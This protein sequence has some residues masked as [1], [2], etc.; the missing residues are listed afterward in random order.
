MD[1]LKTLRSSI[2]EVKKQDKPE[3]IAKRC[4]EILKEVVE[5]AYSESNVKVPLNASLLELI[6][7]DVM[8]AY[9]GDQDIRNALHYVRIL[10]MNAEHGKRVKKREANLAINNIQF[11]IDFIS[12]KNSC[13]GS[14]S[15]SK[16]KYMS[17][18][19]TRKIYIDKYLEEAGWE[20]VEAKGVKIPGKASVEI[21]VAGMP[22]GQKK[23]YC[24]YV[25]YGRDGKPLAIVEAKKS[26]VDPIKGR[27]QVDLYGDCMKAVY[28]YKPILYYTNGYSIKIMDGIYP[29]RE[30]S[31]FHTINELELMLQRRNRGNIVDLTIND[32]ITNRPYQKMAITNL[33]EHFNSMRRR[34][35]LVM[36]TGTGKT[37]VAVSLVDVL[38]RNKWVKNVL[39]LADRTALVSQAKRAFNSLLPDMSICELSGSEEKD[40]NARLMF[41]TYQTMIKYIDSENKEFSIGRFDLIIIDEA[42]R[43]V[44]NKYGA[45]FNYFD[46][47]LIGLTATPKDEVDSNTYTLFGCESGVPN[48]DYTLKD[49][50]GEE[51]LVPYKVLNKTT[52]LYKQGTKYNDLS[53][54]EKDDLDEYV[55]EIGQAPEVVATKNE[56][57]KVLY[58]KDTCRK[59]LEDA[60]NYGIKVNSGETIAKTII[61][62]YD[63][64]HA[65]LIVD[66]FHEMYPALDKNYCQLVDNYVNYAD[67]LVLKFDTDDDFR[68]A[69]SVDMLDT[70]ID[71][72]AVSNLIFFKP[73]KSK[74]K[75]LQM[76]GRGTRLCPNLFGPG[77][78]KKYFLIF[79]YCGNFEYFEE[80]PEGIDPKQTYSLSQATFDV[81]LD[82]LYELQK[83]QYQQNPYTKAYYDDLKKTLRQQ[84]KTVKTH[85]ERVM[86]RTEMQYIDKYCQDGLWDS[87]SAV[88]VREMQNHITKVIDGGSS[89][90]YQARSFDY[91]MLKVQKAI[92][93]SGDL[94]D[95][96]T[97]IRVIRKQAKYL[98]DKKASVPQVLSK[99]NDLITLGNE[100]FWKA[101]TFEDI[102]DMRLAVRDVMQFVDN[103]H[104][105]WIVNLRDYTVDSSVSGD[106]FGWADIR[107]YREKVIDYLFEHSSSPVIKKIQQLE[108][109]TNDD[110]NEL[111]KVLWT[112]LGTK[113]DYDKIADS[114]NV[115]VFVRSLVGLD[116][117]VINKKF[118]E[119]LS[120]NMFNSQQ[121]EFIKTIINYVRENGDITKEDLIE[122]SP[123]DNYDLLEL[124]DDKIIYVIDVVSTF[125]NCVQV[126]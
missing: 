1:K 67:D 11:F 47:F 93:T 74:I 81:S 65:K 43:S 52:V 30:V 40:M 99:I 121:Q 48:F 69:V 94:K 9:I 28:G 102:E 89:G 120:N 59:V 23:G 117:T 32:S 98:I 108:K 82:V 20:V 3:E 60:M 36:A 80:H 14:S 15:V 7:S 51:Y 115:A 111:Q 63:H 124:F 110:L 25:L 56:L 24:D 97:S 17:E 101:P 33:C 114:E 116:Q 19:E 21:E 119:Y 73:V 45:I 55:I 61:F 107:T 12:A 123:F 4:R 103:S 76:I 35:L 62:A 100:D 91:R 22:N 26:S 31:G 29:D 78:D 27:H 58:N 34:G 106:S 18:A 50:V 16:P 68:I 10:G 72:P 13:L 75:F 87:L 109:I 96:A 95:A 85:S 88:M 86:V 2:E 39:F 46:S 70:G 71:V 92:I 6:G 49:A 83:L 44:F 37:R 5:E 126:A 41:S 64:N 77:E 118:N 125:H 38:V 84:V 53:Q 54:Q 57:F 90:D 42:H 79:D 112:E 113:E 122:T 8:Y 105:S 104:K 66:C